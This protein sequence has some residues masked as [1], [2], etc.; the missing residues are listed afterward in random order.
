[1]RN[2]ISETIDSSD[3]VSRNVIRGV[4]L[5]LILASGGFVAG[6]A[7]GGQEDPVSTEVTGD[8]SFENLV[9]TSHGNERQSRLAAYNSSGDLYYENSTFSRY[10]DVDPVPNTTHTVEVVAAEY[11]TDGECSQQT[12]TRNMI[13]RVN[14]ST[15]ESEQIFTHIT[16]EIGNTRWHDADRISE[17]EYVIADIYSD[18]VWVVNTTTEE[19]TWRWNMQSRYPISSGGDWPD[20]WT[21][22]NDVEVVSGDRIMISPRNHDQV[23]FLD[24]GSGVQEN[25]TLG[26]DGDRETL[27]E[28][29]NPDFIPEP[30][31]GPAVLV[32]DSQ[33]DRVV[34]YQR[35]NGSWEQEWTYRSG[36]TA[37]V[38]DADRLPNGNTLIT[39][40]NSNVVFEIDQNNTLQWEVSVE[41]PYDAEILE[42][43]DESAGGESAK[44]LELDSSTATSDSEGGG[45]FSLSR[46]ANFGISIVPDK[47]VN[48]IKYVLPLWMGKEQVV[49]L[50]AF[51]AAVT[52]W[53]TVEYRWSRIA[54]SF[55]SPIQI[56]KRDR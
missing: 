41:K 34:E 28:Q 14:L 31:G 43:G 17:S 25:Y 11:I 7:V 23:I 32:A 12:C 22:M 16:P 2:R 19:V 40:T 33:N 9:V 26:S 35:V 21:H 50:F 37:W 24:P 27:Y 54:I 20:D 8:A 49:A 51:L 44:E 53:T 45:G 56:V 36:R 42:T 15:R 52:T 5:L 4:F 18:S 3:I 30:Q 48:A 29:H 10:F 6:T 1:M 55:G 46:I 47:I 39:G 13:L 38:R